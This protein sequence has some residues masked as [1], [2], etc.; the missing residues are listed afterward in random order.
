M[1][2]AAACGRS[3]MSLQKGQ[4]WHSSFHRSFAQSFVQAGELGLLTW[5]SFLIR[6]FGLGHFFRPCPSLTAGLLARHPTVWLF[7]EDSDLGL[8]Y[9]PSGLVHRICLVSRMM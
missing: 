6:W 1:P 2:E 7:T 3:K 5:Q 4:Y 9:R 8:F